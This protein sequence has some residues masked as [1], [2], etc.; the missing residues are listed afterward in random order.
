MLIR[1]GLGG[2]QAH[3]SESSMLR[4]F[5]KTPH[6]RKQACDLLITLEIYACNIACFSSLTNS[7]AFLPKKKKL[8]SMNPN[9]DSMWDPHEN[10]PIDIR[11]GDRNVSS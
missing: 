2:P 10:M 1:R 7:Q 9:G 11:K 5:L 8:S 3:I 4:Q 6:M